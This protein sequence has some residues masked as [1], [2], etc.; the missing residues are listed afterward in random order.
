[1]NVIAPILQFAR[2]RPGALALI[3]ADRR[4]TYGELGR[5]VRR[6]AQHLISLGAG[7][8]ERIGLCLK[9][10]ADQ[11]VAMLAIAWM[12]GVAV[13]LD[14]RAKPAEN[15]RFIN[16]LGLAA[17]L[18]EPGA[19]Q[20]GQAPNWKLD[21]DWHGAVAGTQV[22]LALL[23]DGLLADGQR[24]FMISATSGSTGAPKFT[25]MTH[26]QYYFAAAGMLEIM[27]LSGR[28]QFLC[29]SA[30]YY[31]GG[32]NSCL[33]HLLRG[34]GV[35]LYPGPFSAADY[36]RLV[37]QHQITVSVLVPTAVRQLLASARDAPLLPGLAAVFCSGAPL[38]ADE[39]RAALRLL[40]PHFHERYGTAET[41]ATAVLRPEDF[42]GRGESVGQPHSLIAV[43]VVDD[44]DAALPAGQSGKL[45]LRG[46]GVAEPLPGAAPANFRN[47]WFYPGE[48]AC[49]DAEGFIFIQ[50]RTSDV[51]M[52]S[53]A[54]IYPA[55]IETVLLNHQAVA[56]A[57][58][59]GQRGADG[60][61]IVMAFVVARLPVSAGDLMAHCRTH[62]TP[63]K[64]PRHIVL[65][66]GLPK[67]TAGKVDK[68][69]LAKT[70][71]PEKEGSRYF[72]EK[73]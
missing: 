47:G 26:L 29:T 42:A 19:A 20:A 13:P 70:L 1:M 73:K 51:M 28:H 61:D 62:L 32:R 72:F 53:G 64:V 25:Q 58:V 35:V 7:P 10:R 41:L 24:V 39:K 15:A 14:W 30:L 2:Y 8:G 38:Y 57:A 5:L 60:E 36:L 54:K 65:T 34:D 6:T 67:N 4:I 22:S 52:R 46:P 21:A 50:G 68:I 66:A 63:H 23:E 3:D 45:R 18:T 43:E 56:E 71:E 33:A 11:I 31:S 69:S 12:G 27:G 16:D 55:E 59:F 44:G 37:E 40:S 49:L 9:D 17:V 48:I